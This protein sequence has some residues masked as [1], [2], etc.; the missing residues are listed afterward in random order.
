MKL[1]AAPG[2]SI[3]RLVM[4]SQCHFVVIVNGI[5]KNDRSRLLVAW[6]EGGKGKKIED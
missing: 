1:L 2:H 5:G 6:W 3:L 4:C